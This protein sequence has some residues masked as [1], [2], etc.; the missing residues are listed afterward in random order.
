MNNLNFYPGIYKMIVLAVCL[1]TYVAIII[2]H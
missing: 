2:K 1:M